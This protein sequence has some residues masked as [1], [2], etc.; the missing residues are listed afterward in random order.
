M[1]ISTSQFFDASAANYQR[2]Y[3]NT[4]TTGQEVSSG[5][6]VNTAADD[7]TGA[8]RLLQ[9]GQ[10][11]SM[12]DQYTANITSATAT[13]TQSE[14]ALTAITNAMQ[15]AKELIVGGA[16][17]TNTDKDRQANAAELT[18]IQ[19]QVLS[20]MNS[21]DANGQYLFSGSKSSTPPYS[22]NA[23]G[24]YSYNGDQTSTTVPIGNGLTVATNTTGWA[25][26]EQAVNTTRT[27]TSMTSPAVDDGR[28]TLSGGQVSNSAT[29][30]SSFSSGQPY[31]VSFLSSTQ[32]KITDASGTDVT[33]EA[34]Q[35]G[36]FSSA[37]ASTQTIGFRGLTLNLNTNLSAADNATTATADA[38][39]AGHSFQ[40]TA[41]PD[42]FATSRSAG[43]ASTTV[44]TSSAETNATAY[45]SSFPPG[46]AILKF[47]SATAFDLYASPI[48]ANSKP[49]S[50]GSTV[51]T[52]NTATPPVTT[53]T[54]TAAGITFNLSGSPAAT[55]TF[56]V[57]P[58][59]HQS[60][61]ILNTLGA[62]IT[63]LNTPA[64][65]DPVALQKLS[66]A[67][68]S[69]LGNLTQS[70]TLVSSAGSNSG[71][72][73]AILISQ[74]ATN[75]T[76]TNGNTIAQSAIRD[77]DPVAS[78]TQLTLQTTMLSAAQ[79]AFSKISQLGLFN[80]I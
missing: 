24:T 74:S 56:T 44:I 69:A 33:A 54:A 78:Y 67:M 17:G 41:A 6:K 43:N 16:N 75:D 39:M 71:A 63:A 37:N 34:G 61:N 50:S 40:V 45:N 59:T 30:N 18:Q 27:S 11:S 8:A 29:F 60:Q 47:T 55:D 7:P 23:D 26:F 25:A 35:N 58:N 76:L 52:T 72:R 57:Q 22:Q 49:V 14:S 20:L 3:N 31:T 79:L 46:G 53:T 42:T 77:A 80:K 66:T 64:D 28:I 51:V 19:G 4:L 15:R 73:Q 1:R 2:I 68:D 32:Y 12:L 13:M 5:T 10:Q 38:A 65:G 36:T 9:L 48:T 70:E 21:Q 62:A